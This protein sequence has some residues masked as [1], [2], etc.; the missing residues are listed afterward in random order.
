[1]YYIYCFWSIENFLKELG[2]FCLIRT[3]TDVT[4]LFSKTWR[5]EN[6]SG[7]GLRGPKQPSQ[8]WLGAA[9]WQISLQC[10]EL[11]CPS[12]S[13]GRKVSA[14]YWKCS[15]TRWPFVRAVPYLHRAG[16]HL[17]H[18]TIWCLKHLIEL[19]FLGEYDLVGHLGRQLSMFINFKVM[20]NA[21]RS[22]DPK[23]ITLFFRVI[24]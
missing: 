1:M 23:C 15:E 7:D 18:F 24:H 8:Q 17:V 21:Q 9:G 6:R 14:C 22:Q 19:C 13:L 5:A 2:L 20:S 3:N 12:G 10:E 4:V 16:S 11:F